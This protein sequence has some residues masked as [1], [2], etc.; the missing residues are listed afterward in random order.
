VL[1]FLGGEV[2]PAF[3]SEWKEALRHLPVNAT[4]H[5]QPLRLLYANMC[6]VCV[7]IDSHF[8][9]ASRLLFTI[10]TELRIGKSKNVEAL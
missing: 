10:A 2:T 4:L 7:L 6:S 1:V 8:S 9:V 5:Y 3:L